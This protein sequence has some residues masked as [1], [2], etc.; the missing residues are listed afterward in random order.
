MRLT[1][2]Q[3][4]AIRRN[5]KEYNK[6]VRFL[7]RMNRKKGEVVLPPQYTYTEVKSLIDS[8]QDYRDVL[9]YLRKIGNSK[10]RIK[11]TE[12]GVRVLE[13]YYNLTKKFDIQRRERRERE[14]E[15]GGNVYVEGIDTGIPSSENTV[16]QLSQ[17]V[18]NITPDEV[19]TT[20]GFELYAQS[21]FKSAMDSDLKRRN[22]LYYNNLLKSLEGSLSEEERKEIISRIKSYVGTGKGK[23]ARLFRMVDI[24]LHNEDIALP[25][26]GSKPYL[27]MD[28]NG[29]THLYNLYMD[30]F[31]SYGI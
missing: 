28:D 16:A 3:R 20:R 10:G 9:G 24:S 4:D 25:T 27:I 5:L 17:R 19:T 21:A 14:I 31:E 26:I 11:T 7:E 15:K 1:K 18:T 23:Y 13:T 30:V 12:S 8:E 29:H 2:R 6:N 22:I